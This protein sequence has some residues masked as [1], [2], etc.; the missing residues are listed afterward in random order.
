[1]PFS[2]ASFKLFLQLAH[3]DQERLSMT[4]QQAQL[5][6]KKKIKQEDLLIGILQRHLWMLV[7]VIYGPNSVN[8]SGHRKLE[9]SAHI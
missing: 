3:A 4:Q 6:H 7:H 9:S 8:H 1:M 2:L 5:F